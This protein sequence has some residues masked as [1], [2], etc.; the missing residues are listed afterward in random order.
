M[1]LHE[2]LS[3]VRFHLAAAIYLTGVATGL[4]PG[5][6]LSFQ[7]EKEARQRKGKHEKE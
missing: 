7:E 2:V 6:V 3:D 4:I 1:Y 5:L